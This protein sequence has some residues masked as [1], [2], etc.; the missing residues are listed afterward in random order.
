MTIMNFTPLQ[1]QLA[2]ATRPCPDHPND[3]GCPGRPFIFADE[4][5]LSCDNC[6][7]RGHLSFPQDSHCR[8]CRPCGGVGWVPAP[9]GPAWRQAVRALG[10]TVQTTSVPFK[11]GD[12]VWIDSGVKPLAAVSP[13][14]G[15]RDGAA[16][17]TAVQ[18]A[19]MTIP[20][21]QLGEE[22]PRET[23]RAAAI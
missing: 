4:V 8:P 14:A 21:A 7:G 15:L 18:Q 11:L 13:G 3:P 1:A 17:F 10:W 19:V 23:G 20:G 6:L 2:G 9:D 22:M 16:F 12:D 5:R